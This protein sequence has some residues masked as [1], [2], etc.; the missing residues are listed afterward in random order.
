MISFVLA[1]FAGYSF[2]VAKEAN[3]LTIMLMQKD[4]RPW[5]QIINARIEPINTDEYYIIAAVENAV[6][7]VALSVSFKIAI[8]GFVS[9]IATSSAAILP[10]NKVEL[11]SPRIKGPA[12]KENDILAW[13]IE[14]KDEN[15]LKYKI[16]QKK[17]VRPR[18]L[19]ELEY[20]PERM[21]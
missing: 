20:I 15:N 6:G 1:I 8:N 3:E 13:I 5:L 16:T 4:D 10:K 19:K 11:I 9:D 2:L 12:L 21:Y 14:F 7:G 18:G 17:L